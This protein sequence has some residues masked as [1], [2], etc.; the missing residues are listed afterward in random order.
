MT[1]RIDLTGQ[2]FGR[3]TVLS[4]SEARCR[5]KEKHPRAYWLCLCDCG[6]QKVLCAQ[7]LRQRA[8]KSCGCLKLQHARE[9]GRVNGGK[10][11]RTDIVGQQ[12][13]RLTV[14]SFSNYPNKRPHWLCECDCGNQKIV[15]G[16]N[17]KSG[18]TRSCGC[19]HTENSNRQALARRGIPASNR[20]H[21]K[22]R[23][24]AY[25][26]WASMTQRCENPKRPG[27][28]D[29]GGRGIK[30]CERWRR[31]FSDYEEDLLRIL[32]PKPPGMSLDRIEND[33]DYEPSNVRWATQKEQ[34]ANQR[35][36]KRIDAFTEAELI[37]ELKRRS[38]PE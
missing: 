4:F 3:L 31:S 10:R 24:A 8:T 15:T 28:E 22:S 25:R 30:V 13:G 38:A 33:G 23:T 7:D 9:L 19:L 36:R 11:P 26:S 29:Y 32:G 17:L 21:G 35:K 16:L 34:V 6:K 2:R 5:G 20:T 14:I 1:K 18:H 37:A 27:W 12:F